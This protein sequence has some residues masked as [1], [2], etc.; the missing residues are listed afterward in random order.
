[1]GALT[2]STRSLSA[3]GLN[4]SNKTYSGLAAAIAGAVSSAAA[5]A[6]TNETQ[7]S[8]TAST[9]QIRYSSETGVTMDDELAQLTVLQNSY[10]ASAKVISTV[11]SMYDTLLNLGS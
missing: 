3:G 4:A 1:M 6:S 10:A 2:D 8:A 7:L 9:L 11:Q 5:T